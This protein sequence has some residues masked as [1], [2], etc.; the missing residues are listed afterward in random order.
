VAIVDEAALPSVDSGPFAQLVLSSAGPAEVDA[1]L[2]LS[3][4]HRVQVEPDG[5]DAPVVIRVGPFELDQH[6]YTITVETRPLPLTHHEFE[7]LRALLAHAGRPLSRESLL[8]VLGGADPSPRAIDCHV[9]A[10]RSKLG[11]HRSSI[12]TVRGLGYLAVTA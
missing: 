5:V 8:S 2:R 3:Q 1:R 4:R 11:R 12:R 6:A 9:R 7:V 10:L